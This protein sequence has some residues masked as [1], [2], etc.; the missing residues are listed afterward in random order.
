M[1]YCSS[2]KV[3]KCINLSISDFGKVASNFLFIE[4]VLSLFTLIY[5]LNMFGVQIKI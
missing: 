4:E 1:I 5:L 2:K 3:Q